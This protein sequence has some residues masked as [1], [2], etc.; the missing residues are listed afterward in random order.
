ME[1]DILIHTKQEAEV[2]R[3]AYDFLSQ[4]G[5]LE[6][7]NQVARQ[8][9]FQITRDMTFVDLG[10][11]REGAIGGRRGLKNEVR[12]GEC[13]DGLMRAVATRSLCLKIAQQMLRETNVFYRQR[14][15]SI[16]Q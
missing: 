11:E 9:L 10:I 16:I 3:S 8:A 4:F 5:E 13:D 7:E 1:K 14:R 6:V 2:V 12:T 15:Q